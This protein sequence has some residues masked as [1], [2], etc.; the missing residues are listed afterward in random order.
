MNGNREG[1]GSAAKKVVIEMLDVS[2]DWIEKVKGN[3]RNLNLSLLNIRLFSF[4][5]FDLVFISNLIP[6]SSFENL[7]YE[8]AR[9]ISFALVLTF[10]SESWFSLH[11]TH[12]PDSVL[13]DK[14]SW[15]DGIILVYDV[16]DRHSFH[17]IVRLI[18]VISN[19]RDRFCPILLL[20][21]KQDIEIG[22]KVDSL[23]GK[24]LAAKFHAH[25]SEVR[26]CLLVLIC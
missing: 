1:R 19:V 8:K 13:K 11:P 2:G 22:R 6:R 25:F 7:L 14:I 16:S 10:F 12:Q 20:G 18:Q 9:K 24:K 21:N 15:S 4:S 17:S 5:F 23:E 3:K 26:V